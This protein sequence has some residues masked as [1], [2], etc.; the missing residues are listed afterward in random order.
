MERIKSIWK[1]Y[2]D[3]LEKQRIV[4]FEAHI[5]SSNNTTPPNNNTK[6]KPQNNEKK[7]FSKNAQ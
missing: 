2:S 6:L 1:I 4:K 5:C 3:E 7:H